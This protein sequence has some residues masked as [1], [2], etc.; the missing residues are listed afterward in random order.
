MPLRRIRMT[1]VKLRH[2]NREEVLMQNGLRVVCL[3]AIVGCLIGGGSSEVSADAFKDVYKSLK[4]IEAATKVGSAK[5]ELN[6]LIVDAMTE[7]ELAPVEGKHAEA[8]PHLRRAM[9]AY[10]V[11]M[12]IWNDYAESECMDS[13]FYKATLEDF[14]ALKTWKWGKTGVGVGDTYSKGYDCYIIIRDHWLS[15][16]GACLFNEASIALDQARKSY[17]SAK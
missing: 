2:Q 9:A 8:M 5:N 15:T 4:R 1:V 14:P 6:K 16:W 10:Q 12:V 13:K 3:L 17:T 7:I 11:V